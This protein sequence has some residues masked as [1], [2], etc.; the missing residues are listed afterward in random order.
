MSIWRSRQARDDVMKEIVFTSHVLPTSE[1]VQL[2]LVNETSNIPVDDAMA[3]ARE[4]AGRSPKALRGTTKLINRLTNVSATGHF[5]T[6][7]NI[8]FKLIGSGNQ[9]K[10]ITVNLENR[11]LTIRDVAY[12]IVI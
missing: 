12:L 7:R 8:I 3:M 10:A 4:F 6:G 2:G 5:T 9:V 1:G 11:A